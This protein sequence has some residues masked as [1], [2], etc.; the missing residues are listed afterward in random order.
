MEP[1]DRVEVNQVAPH[2]WVLAVHGDHDLSNIGQVDEALEAVFAAGSRMVVDFS[3]AGFIDST[4]L[5]SLLRARVRADERASDDLVVV[6]PEGTTP[7][8]LINLTGIEDRVLVY[9]SRAEA[10][11]ALSRDRC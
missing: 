4:V 9:E 6:A 1:S 2:L 11:A 3:D 8:R 7:R 5:R 10:L